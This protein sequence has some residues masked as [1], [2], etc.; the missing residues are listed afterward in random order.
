MTLTHQLLPNTTSESKEVVRHLEALKTRARDNS[1]T[2]KYV[3]RIRWTM[4]NAGLL[5][6]GFVLKT[7]RVCEIEELEGGNACVFRTWQTFAGLGAKVLRR[8]W[9]VVLRERSEDLVRDLRRRSGVLEGREKEEKGAEGKEGE[10][11][12]KNE[13]QG[14][15]S[16]DENGDVDEIDKMHRMDV[17]RTEA[18]TAAVGSLG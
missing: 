10:V 7:E 15:S 12:R 11:R 5:A 13:K 4:D 14:E 8:K 6:P 1:S 17:E 9:E 18:A 3:T 2:G 16:E